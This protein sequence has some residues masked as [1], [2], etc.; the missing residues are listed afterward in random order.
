MSEENG[1][2]EIVKVKIADY[3]VAGS[4]AILATYGLGSCIGIAIYDEKLKLGGLAHIMLPAVGNVSDP[5][6]F[7]RYADTAL[8]LMIAD[9]ENRGS[10]RGSMTAKIAGG[11]SMFP[12]INKENAKV[13]GEKNVEAVREY[14]NQVEIPLLGADTGGDYGRSIEFFTETGKM[15]VSSIRHAPKS[16]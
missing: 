4:P 11:A 12:S 8:K 5:K 1:S 13:I 7:P 6:F 14:L 10:S 16:L 3:K 9:M 2:M 15:N